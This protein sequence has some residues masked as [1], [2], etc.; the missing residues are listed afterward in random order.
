MFTPNPFDREFLLK[1]E[2]EWQIVPNKIWKQYLQL[3]EHFYALYVFIVQSNGGVA[4]TSLLVDFVDLP[5]PGE[6]HNTP[7]FASKWPQRMQKPLLKI[8]LRK[9][10]RF[11]VSEKT[12]KGANTTP[13]LAETYLGTNK[14][15]KTNIL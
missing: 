11:R 13:S 9:I 10:E 14:Q 8:I 1:Y 4:T 6:G 12:L 3:K 15:K 2:R 5:Y 7:I